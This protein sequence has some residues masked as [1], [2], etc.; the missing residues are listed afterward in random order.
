MAWCG[1]EWG[2][3]GGQGSWGKSELPRGVGSWHQTPGKPYENMGS[4]KPSRR[5]S[6]SDPQS[7]DGM[8]VGVRQLARKDAEAGPVFQEEDSLPLALWASISARWQCRNRAVFPRGLEDICTLVRVFISLENTESVFVPVF[9]ILSVISD[10]PITL[11][12]LDKTEKSYSQASRQ[13]KARAANC[14]TRTV[15]KMTL[16]PCKLL[17]RMP[18]G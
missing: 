17:S 11:G 9:R 6:G 16:T 15:S 5:K 14:S 4:N 1:E 8:S 3:E 2:T 7:T 13:T 10:W 18:P 12:K